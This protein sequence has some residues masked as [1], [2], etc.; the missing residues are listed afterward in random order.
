MGKHCIERFSERFSYEGTIPYLPLCINMVNKF[1][2]LDEAE[3]LSTA[4]EA[5]LNA[6]HSFTRREAEGNFASYASRSIHNAL[7]TLYWQTVHNRHDSL[8]EMGEQNEWN[9]ANEALI[10]IESA[11]ESLEILDFFVSFLKTLDET[12]RIL[13]RFRVN[14]TDI[15]ISELA[16]L[17][18]EH[19]NGIPSTQGGLTKRLKKLRILYQKYK[20]EEE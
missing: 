11:Y 5:L 16:T 17:L 8:E 1:H 13:L 18:S 12:N 2:N 6:Y 7:T 10:S 3:A 20:D 14:H 19:Y 4:T 15:S 9:Q